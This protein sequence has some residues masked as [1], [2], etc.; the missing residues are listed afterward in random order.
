[1]PETLPSQLSLSPALCRAARALLNWSPAE[2]A[3]RAH[4][5]VAW[6]KEFEQ[7]HEPGVDADPGE[8]ARLRRA[9]EAAGVDFL[10]AGE[11]STGG[12]EGLRLRQQKGGYIAT[13]N[14]SSANDG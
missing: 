13:E 5:P 7:G 14:L 11:A 2:L 8:A 6:L 9:L 4:V 10:A 1:M 12:G 3:E